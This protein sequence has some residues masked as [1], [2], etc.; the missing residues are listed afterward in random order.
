MVALADR[1][2]GVVARPQIVALGYSRAAIG[3]AVGAG[4]L[5]T[6]HRAVYVVGHRHLG[7]TGHR[8]AA[9][10]AC[11]PGAVLGHGSAAE[12]W[13]IRPN[14]Q[15][16]YD[17]T[18]PRALR[19]RPGLRPHHVVLQEDEHTTL[20]GLPLTTVARTLLDL[21]ASLD[22]HRLERALER[23]ETARLLDLRSL[24][25]LLD[26]YPRRAG[27]PKLRR[28]VAGD[29]LDARVTRSDFEE[30][31]LAFLDEHRL[32]RSSTNV[33]VPIDD[34]EGP[35]LELDVAWPAARLA[36]ELDPR[37][38]HGTAAAFERDRRKD[39]RLLLAGWR[40][41]RLTPRRLRKDPERV[42][43]LLRRLLAGRPGLR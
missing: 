12:A 43:G 18:V 6:V 2:G 22:S 5:T 37:A 25:R 31:F 9:V 38:T 28:L 20:D 14:A 39:Q 30:E 36:V 1:Q 15:A 40:V 16:R 4:L 11:G 24:N 41:V 23:A 19:P 8:F 3:R 26:R 34:G 27:T 10:L 35:G 29:S 7:P 42:T 17:V 21:A 13:G 33:W 32:P